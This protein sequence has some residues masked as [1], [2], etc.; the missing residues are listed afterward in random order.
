[1]G[2][3]RTKEKEMRYSFTAWVTRCA[4][5]VNRHGISEKS[6]F[7]E[8]VIFEMEE[9]AERSLTDAET[10]EVEKILDREV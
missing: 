1:M 9:G 6:S 8:E 7:V 4:D 10:A 2:L 5:I 3:P